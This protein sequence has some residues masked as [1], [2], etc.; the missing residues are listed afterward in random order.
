MKPD[1]YRLNKYVETDP[2]MMSILH[3][4]ELWSINTE[5]QDH[6]K[7]YHKDTRTIILRGP[8]VIT[9]E[10]MLNSTKTI[11]YPGYSA[12]PEARELIHSLMYDVR[13]VELGRA[14]V[15][16]LKPGGVIAPHRDSGNYPAEFDRFHI[17][18]HSLEGNTFKVGEQEVWMQV[19]EQ[20]WINNKALHSVENNSEEPRVHLI[21]DIKVR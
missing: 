1:I 9:Y 4:P 6:P 7:S 17:P 20:W 3:K 11:E 12:L 14:M 10:S 13:G 5:R 18:L 15:V 8:E 2:L 21:V 19:G 16:M